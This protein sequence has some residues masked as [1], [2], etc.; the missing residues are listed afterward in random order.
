VRQLEI[1]S[2]A[3]WS[4]ESEAAADAGEAGSFS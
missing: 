2:K 3:S 4:R 1:A